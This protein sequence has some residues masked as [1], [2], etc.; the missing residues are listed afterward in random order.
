[1]C[2]GNPTTRGAASSNHLAQMGPYF[3]TISSL[4]NESRAR[5]ASA[6]THVRNLPRIAAKVADLQDSSSK[7]VASRTSVLLQELRHACSS[8]RVVDITSRNGS[9]GEQLSTQSAK[10][11]DL[12]TKSKAMQNELCRAIASI[13][14]GGK[15]PSDFSTFFS[16]SF[17]KLLSEKRKMKPIGSVVIPIENAPM[18]GKPLVRPLTLAD[19]SQLR[20]LHKVFVN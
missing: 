19:G 1:M 17:S 18:Q 4:L 7:E 5:A 20:H 11:L 12:K 15:A 10:L 14:K 3:A 16:Q 2:A 6:R 13:T 8:P 9:P